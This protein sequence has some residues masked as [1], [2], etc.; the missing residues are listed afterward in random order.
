MASSW[1]PSRA[2]WL[3]FAAG[4]GFAVAG[5]FRPEAV[6]WMLLY[7]AVLASLVAVSGIAGSRRP[8]AAVERTHR[9]TLAARSA[10]RVALQVR[11]LRARPVRLE[12][13]DALPEDAQ[14]EGHECPVLLAGGGTVGLEYTLVPRRRGPCAFPG[15]FVRFVGPL[16]LTRVVQQLANPTEARVFPNVGRVREYELL[17]RRGRLSSIGVRRIMGRGVGMEFAGLRDYQDDDIRYVHWPATARR[18]RLVVK[19]FEPERN[20]AVI[21]CLDLGRHMLGEVEG[22]RKVEHMLDAAVLLLHAAAREGDMA[23]LLAFDEDVR[24]FVAPRKGRLQASAVTEAAHALR[25]TAT[26]PHYRAAFS[27]LATAWRRRALLVVFTD[28]EDEDQ[29]EELCM[30]LGPLRARYVVL[31][32]LVTDPGV[33]RG[34]SLAVTD[35]DTLAARASSV[36]YLEGRERAQLVLRQA[37]IETLEAPPEELGAALVSAYLRIKAQ[38]RI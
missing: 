34:R 14:G 2:A 15:T 8:A 37:G 16:G 18:G 26:Q 9:P 7:D 36:W 35:R 21:A 3:L 5:A 33:E 30:A 10:N 12:L 11:N 4:A 28:A 20:Q 32:V 25:P 29:A 19:E 1:A 22:E 24:T 17:R 13:A 31:V 6:G 38:A 23:G 27:Y